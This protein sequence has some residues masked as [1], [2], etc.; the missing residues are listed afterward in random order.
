MS[1]SNN[2]NNSSDF[3]S[4]GV[5]VPNK[6]YPLPSDYDKLTEKG[7]QQARFAILY[8]QSTPENLVRAWQCF[9]QWYLKADPIFYKRPLPSPAFHSQLVYD[10]G[11]FRRNAIAAPRGSAKTTVITREVPL[12]FM[13]TRN[14][15]ETSISKATDNMV[16][17]D[18]D[19]IM[20]QMEENQALLQEFGRL[21]PTARTGIWNRH[22]IRIANGNS[23]RGISVEG[24]KRGG[25]PD[26]FILDD[27]EYDP[28]TETATVRNIEKFQTL[29]FKIILP[30]LDEGSTG[31]YW[32]GTM[33]GKRSFLYAACQGDDKR[34]RL[35]NRRIL[36][37][38]SF[39][40][41]SSDEKRKN[42]LNRFK[43]LLWPEKWSEE[44]LCEREEEIGPAA[45][46]SEFLNAPVSEN[47]R[48][49]KVDKYKN[50]Y[51]IE[52]DIHPSDPF[53][54]PKETAIQYCRLKKG[55]A[56]YE[57]VN[58]PYNDWLRRLFRFLVIDFA[59]TATAYS[60]FSCII[61]CAFDRWDTLWAL[62]GWIGKVSLDTIDVLINQMGMKWQSHM[63]CPE[64]ASIQ[65][66][67][68]TKYANKV[69]DDSITTG[70][71]PKVVPPKFP[72]NTTKGEKIAALEWRFNRGRIK[73]PRGF[74]FDTNT[75]WRILYA[76]IADFTVDLSL[77]PKD[78]AIDTLGMTSFVRKKTGIPR[79]TEPS[80]STPLTQLAEGKRVDSLTG[81]PLISGMNA[82]DIP[83][84]IIDKMIN[85]PPQSTRRSRRNSIP[86]RYHLR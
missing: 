74:P 62:D 27:P 47:E 23:L 61:S 82:G 41:I 65:Q 51:V 17:S 1:N 52:G 83:R 81:L 3:T 42:G 7:K 15:F 12:L 68:V 72:R 40:G 60:D 30:M 28:E 73:L 16:E 70:W 84:D 25:R 33:I 5:S 21:K 55:S 2:S 29:L 63:V 35:W 4:G 9:R 80:I 39:T 24:R 34:F 46:A 77:L 18:F 59:Y 75:F 85:Q 66:N 22:H 31:I 11:A 53:K 36:A 37:A 48:L 64:S 44:A 19:F 6:F 54:T 10:M 56:D 79:T 76:Q 50:T 45:F 86:S 8:D 78:D 20:Q 69:Q 14:N 58:E 49:L 26:L 67:I 13:Y 32:I 38:A 57:Q 43:N 71:Y